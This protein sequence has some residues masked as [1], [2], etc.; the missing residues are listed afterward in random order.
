MYVYTVYSNIICTQK[1]LLKKQMHSAFL[2]QGNQK[3]RVIERPC[4]QRCADISLEGD[5]VMSN[6][7]Q[8]SWMKQPSTKLSLTHLNAALASVISFLTKLILIL[9]RCPVLVVPV[10]ELPHQLSAA[11]SW[12]HVDRTQRLQEYP[13]IPIVNACATLYN[14]PVYCVLALSRTRI[15]PNQAAF[16]FTAW[17][18]IAS[19]FSIRIITLYNGSKQ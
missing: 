5:G 11:E 18:E 19:I 8:G 1:I 4:Q 16:W 9:T 14:C 10:L 3:R 15:K 13:N 7:C 2:R 17:L 12:Q 6:G